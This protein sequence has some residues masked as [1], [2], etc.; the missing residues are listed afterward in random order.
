[1][2]PY[3]H[4]DLTKKWALEAGFSPEEADLIGRA[5]L[6]LDTKCWVKPWAHFILFGA[7]PIC[8]ILAWR[9]RRRRDLRLLGYALHA[10]QD[11]LGHGWILPFQHNPSLDEWSNATEATQKR[12][13]TESQAMLT[14]YLSI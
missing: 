3:V 4:R 1:M 5:N 13:A 10:K 12:I 7:C 14:R 8:K 11:A 9:A 2:G 6:D